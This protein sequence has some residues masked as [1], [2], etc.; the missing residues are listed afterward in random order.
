MPSP[1][2]YYKDSAPSIEDYGYMI[3]ILILQ[4]CETSY[5]KIRI[6]NKF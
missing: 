6:G 2:F 3:T 5:S 4:Q 1:R